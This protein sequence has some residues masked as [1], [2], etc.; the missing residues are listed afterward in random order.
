MDR[1]VRKIKFRQKPNQV[2]S[3]LPSPAQAPWMGDI[4]LYA[5]VDIR[6]CCGWGYLSRMFE[7]WFIGHHWAL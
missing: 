7:T 2:K 6:M 4:G 1:I 3:R 5:G